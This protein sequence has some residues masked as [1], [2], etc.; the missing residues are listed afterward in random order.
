MIAVALASSPPA[1][2]LNGEIK[3]STLPKVTLLSPI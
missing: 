1:K 3:F 2:G